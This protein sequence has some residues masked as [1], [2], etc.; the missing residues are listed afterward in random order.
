LPK[1]WCFVQN[2]NDKQ[3][4]QHDLDFCEIGAGG[5]TEISPLTNPAAQEHLL[6]KKP[7]LEIRGQKER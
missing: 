7:F 5:K 4:I 6:W 2:L 1:V 3:L